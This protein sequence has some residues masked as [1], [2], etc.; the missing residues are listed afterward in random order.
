MTEIEYRKVYFRIDC[1]YM[2]TDNDRTEM[3]LQE[4]EGMLKDAGWTVDVSRSTGSCPEVSLR[5]MHLY[6]HP[7]EV[8]G[9]VE[10]EMIPVLEEMFKKGVYFSYRRT[11]VYEQVHD[12]TLQQLED[13]LL[14]NESWR[15]QAMMLERC[16]TK[17][18]NLF[19]KW[20]SVRELLAQAIDAHTMLKGIY[21]SSDYA[22]RIKLV[23]DVHDALVEQGFLVASGDLVRTVTDAELKK[24]KSK[25]ARAA[26]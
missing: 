22:L 14:E 15:V 3:C 19:I 18:S 25:A 5:K 11:D 16:R 20:Q 26:L 4:L 13:H 1:G 7:Q 2:T 10:T 6:C 21:E 9:T 23:D 24:M 17:R 12:W 8:S